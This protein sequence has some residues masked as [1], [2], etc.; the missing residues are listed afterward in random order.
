MS[1]ERTEHNPRPGE[2]W[3]IRSVTSSYKATAILRMKHNTTD[4]YEWVIVAEDGRSSVGGTELPDG[5]V[6][7]EPVLP[8][9]HPLPDCAWRRGSDDLER[10]LHAA[11]IDFYRENENL[12]LT[13]LSAYLAAWVV[14]N[15]AVDPT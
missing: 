12:V 14:E 9:R 1:T 15:E 4:A 13:E 7:I 5:W 2:P 10:R 3:L 6:L 8:R 11:L